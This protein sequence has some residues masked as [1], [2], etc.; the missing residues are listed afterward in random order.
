MRNELTTYHSTNAITSVGNNTFI[1]N[2]QADG[3]YQLAELQAFR[4]I[5]KAALAK[6]ALDNTAILA[7]A[8]E[9]YIRE[10]PTGTAD[11][12]RIVENYVNWCI[13]ELNGGGW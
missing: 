6:T 3:M 8:E 5:L 4:G 10:A 12:R 7:L 11:Y 9:R 13:S 2:P 1:V